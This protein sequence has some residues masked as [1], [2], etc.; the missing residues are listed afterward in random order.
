MNPLPPL[1]IG[2]STASVGAAT[3]HHQLQAAAERS[4]TGRFEPQLE[5]W[6]GRT[7]TITAGAVRPLLWG[8][9][10]SVNPTNQCGLH[11]EK[12][13]REGPRGDGPT[14]KRIDELKNLLRATAGVVV[15]KPWLHNQIRVHCWGCRKRCPKNCINICCELQSPC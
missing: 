2:T 11:Y 14:V 4:R 13:G 6:V 5:R 8:C 7:L 12:V 15:M 10:A 9:K 1:T 3:E